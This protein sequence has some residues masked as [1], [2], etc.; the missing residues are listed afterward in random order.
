MTFAEHPA[1]CDQTHEGPIFEENGSGFIEHCHEIVVDGISVDIIQIQH[2]KLRDGRFL[3]RRGPIHAL[4]SPDFNNNLMF[5][6]ATITRMAE[7][8]S[9]ARDEFAALD[10]GDKN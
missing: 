1:W 4:L 2:W 3:F 10:G 9:R 8:L 7:V 5:D 6:L